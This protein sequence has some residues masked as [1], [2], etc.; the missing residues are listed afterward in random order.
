VADALSPNPTDYEHGADCDGTVSFPPELGPVMLFGPGCGY[1]P[2]SEVKLGLEDSAV[3]GVAWP[4]DAADPQLLKWKKDT[5]NPVVFADG[6]PPCS[7]AGRVWRSN[8]TAGP[9]AT[10]SNASG[11]HWNLVC[12]A[13]EWA[14]SVAFC[15][16]L[17]VD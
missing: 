11:G 12:S 8:T 2:K 7:F 10:S 16:D 1:H 3:V 6:S 15:P 14:P 13:G 17:Y 4:E 5:A 9:S